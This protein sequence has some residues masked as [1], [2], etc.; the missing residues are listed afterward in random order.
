MEKTNP[1]FTFTLP[2]FPIFSIIGNVEWAVKYHPHHTPHGQLSLPESRSCSS[3]LLVCWGESQSRSPC[4]A[5][6]TVLRA[7]F[8]KIQRN[9]PWRSSLHSKPNIYHCAA[10]RTATQHVVNRRSTISQN[11][12]LSWLLSRGTN[13]N[14][15]WSLSSL[16]Q[17][18]F[19]RTTLEIRSTKHLLSH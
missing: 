2:I 9:E 14:L 5:T 4:K 10:Q 15:T 17:S 7:S 13:H 8:N 18:V 11:L 3:V 1:S 12:I 6:L 19:V 16:L